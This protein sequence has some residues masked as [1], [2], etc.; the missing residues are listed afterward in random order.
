MVPGL[1]LSIVFLILL[2]CILHGLR[3]MRG[4]QDVPDMMVRIPA[5]NARGLLR[6]LA[7]LWGVVVVA[8]LCSLLLILLSFRKPALDLGDSVSRLLLGLTGLSL[9]SVPILLQMQRH[10]LKVESVNV[11]GDWVDDNPGDIFN[12]HEPEGLSAEDGEVVEPVGPDRES[13]D[14]FQLLGDR[15]LA[16]LEE[17]KPYLDPDFTLDDLARLMGVP[18]HHIYHCL[19]SILNVRFTR[20][21]AEYRIRHAKRLIDEGVG[22]EKSLQTIGLESGFSSRSSFIIAFREV[23]GQTPRDYLR[24]RG[25]A[26]S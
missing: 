7:S 16:T 19:N 12:D 10:L 1:T 3:L 13:L 18:K 23:T 6:L 8:A 15:I 14:R 5:E 2:G 11:G 24:A 17:R 4:F 21:R 26:A 25:E 22:S 20:L 9:L